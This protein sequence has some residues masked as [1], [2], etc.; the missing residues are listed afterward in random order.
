MHVMRPPGSGRRRRRGTPCTTAAGTAWACA[1]ASGEK[2]IGG[3]CRGARRSC[4]GCVSREA[5]RP[6]PLLGEG[7]RAPPLLP[8]YRG[9]APARLMTSYLLKAWRRPCAWIPCASDPTVKPPTASEGRGLGRRRTPVRGGTAPGGA[10]HAPPPAVGAAV[11]PPIMGAAWWTPRRAVRVPLP[12]GIQGRGWL[13][14][15]ARSTTSPTGCGGT[16]PCTS[17]GPR[18]GREIC[19]RWEGSRR[20]I[21]S[22]SPLVTTLQEPTSTGW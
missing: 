4:V 17:R 8:P 21:P 18:G 5:V 22:E 7:P 20:V 2:P 11:L 3:R 1:R 14:G 13:S 16:L 19:A 9:P 15:T 10:V 12:A 6:G